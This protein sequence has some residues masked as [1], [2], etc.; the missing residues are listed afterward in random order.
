MANRTARSSGELPEIELKRNHPTDAV[1]RA[2]GGG[3]AKE[4]KEEEEEKWKL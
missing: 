1:T 2:Q 4:A 3:K